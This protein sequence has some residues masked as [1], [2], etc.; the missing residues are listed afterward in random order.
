[1]SHMVVVLFFSLSSQDVRHQH[2][3]LHFE[4]SILSPLFPLVECTAEMLAPT[5][6]HKPQPHSLP[7]ADSHSH[8]QFN[9]RKYKVGFP[10]SLHYVSWCFLHCSHPLSHSV[11]HNLLLPAEIL[12]HILHLSFCL[13]S[14]VPFEGDKNSSKHLHSVYSWFFLDFSVAQLHT[15]L[16]ITCNFVLH[17]E[18]FRSVGILMKLSLLKL[19]FFI[20]IS[21]FCHIQAALHWMKHLKELH[22][23]LH[24]FLAATHGQ[25]MLILID[26][27]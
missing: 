8:A 5:E 14:P 6:N 23:H 16:Y 2:S 4:G 9:T 12:S 22:P 7:A 25:S 10:P 17:G 24:S 20:W 15:N 13:D 3:L 21:F 27:A 1:M 26:L 11:H 19:C 18:F